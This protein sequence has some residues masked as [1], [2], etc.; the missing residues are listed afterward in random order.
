MG[1]GAAWLASSVREQR[2]GLRQRQGLAETQPRAE[3][4][5]DERSAERPPEAG[6]V[7]IASIH[8]IIAGA[9]NP[10]YAASKSGVLGLTRSMAVAYAAQGIRV[11]AICPGFIDTPMLPDIPS[12]R[13]RMIASA[14]M[15]RLGRP[16]EIG[17]AA[18]F[19]L[20]NDASFVTGQQLVVDGGVVIAD[21]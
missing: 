10:A 18:R 17:T 2:V 11:N 4:K 5:S 1:H 8:G 3:Q 16:D 7:G 21:Y 20:S 6:V 12:L 15:A 13:E 19:L 14:P 9:A